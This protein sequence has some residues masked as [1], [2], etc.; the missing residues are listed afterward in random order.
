MREGHV[1]GVMGAYNSLYGVPTAPVLFCSTICCAS[2]GDLRVTSFRIATP[3]AIFG[4]QHHYVNTPEEAAAAAVKAGCNLCCGG[5]YNALVR[6][7][8]KGLGHRKGY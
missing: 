7:V 3:S 5:D 1:A 8:Q 2:N 6:A 4:G